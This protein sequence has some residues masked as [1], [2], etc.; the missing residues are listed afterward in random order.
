[1]NAKINQDGAKAKF[2]ALACLLLRKHYDGQNAEYDG[3]T[4]NGVFFSIT[5]PE[6]G[7]VAM[8][9]KCFEDEEQEKEIDYLGGEL[10]DL[11]WST[12]EGGI[13]WDVTA[14]PQGIR[15]QA[16][17]LATWAGFWL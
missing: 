5:Q 13:D 4:E 8:Q 12:E 7:E 15:K 10:V 3:K 9:I 1:M 11:R 14:S 2:V 16:E 17:V 6:D